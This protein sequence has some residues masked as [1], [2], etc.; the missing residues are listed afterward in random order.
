MIAVAAIHRRLPPITVIAWMN[1]WMDLGSNPLH[2][3]GPKAAVAHFMAPRS[4]HRLNALTVERTRRA[5]KYADGGGLYLQID[6]GSRAWHFRYRWL[7][8]ERYMGLGSVSLISLSEAREL[9][10]QARKLLHDRVDPLAARQAERAR[11]QREARQ[12]MTF[13]ACA[14][15]YI[16]AH[17]VEWKNPKHRQQWTNTLQTYAS[18]VFGNL[19]VASVDT[20]LIMKAVQ[21]IWAAKNETAARLRGRIETVL[22]WAKV[23]GYRSG[24]NPARWK[25]HLQQL[26]PAR[27]KVHAVKHHAALPYAELPAFMPKLRRM[28]GVAARALEFLILTAVRTGDIRGK[29]RDDRPAMQ[30]AHID[31]TARIWTIP[32]TK[33]DVEHAVPLSDAAIAVLKDVAAFGLKSGI[34]F[35]STDRLGEPLSD[36]AMRSV[37]DRMGEGYETLTAHGFRA[38]FKTWASEATDFQHEVIEAALAHGISDKLEAAYRRGTFFEKR[39]RLMA[40]WADFIVNRRG[41]DKVIPLN[42][43]R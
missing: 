32:K 24:D 37:L 41:S 42:R 29:D 39:R 36:A 11:K 38:T 8:T 3:S 14:E 25:G 43:R 22:D 16:E 12:S 21:P 13:D 27:R 2:A 33:T 40:A 19:P 15:K 35:P 23:N 18:P 26:L 5:G 4:I 20:P 9:A 1:A 30:W 31:L 10:H 28:E 34:V 17:K 7:G 6:G